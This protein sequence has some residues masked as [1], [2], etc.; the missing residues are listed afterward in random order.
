MVSLD[1]SSP[2]DFGSRAVGVLFVSTDDSVPASGQMLPPLT[3]TAYATDL[4]T[5]LADRLPKPTQFDVTT[6]AARLTQADGLGI[7]DG[8]DAALS[9]LSAVHEM[10]PADPH[11]AFQDFAHQFVQRRLSRSNVARRSEARWL[12]EH[13]NEVLL[14]MMQNVLYA[15]G[16]W[17]ESRTLEQWRDLVSEDAARQVE[18]EWTRLVL[19]Q[20]S[21]SRSAEQLER[22]LAATPSGAYRIVQALEAAG[23]LRGGSVLGLEPR[24]LRCWLRQAAETAVFDAGALAW[25][26]LL[27]QESTGRL[28]RE[29]LT[30]TL[31]N[32][33]RRLFTLLL[34]SPPDERS[35]EW[36]L[37][38]ESV[39]E[40]AGDAILTG[41][42]LDDL[43]LMELWE[44]QGSLVL[45]LD[46]YATPRTGC[47][48]ADQ[49]RYGAWLLRTWA[50]AEQLGTVAALP[51][52]CPWPSPDELPTSALDAVDAYLRSEASK[53]VSN[54]PSRYA[55]AGYSLVQR[56]F[57]GQRPLPAH[58]LFA[59]VRLID[60]PS[61]GNA[62][63]LSALPH[64][65]SLLKALVRTGFPDLAEAIW[66]SWA[67]GGYDAGAHVLA[68]SAPDA[69]VVWPHL[70]GPILS[71]MLRLAHEY[72]RCLPFPHLSMDA[73]RVLV[74]TEDALDDD[75]LTYL[76]FALLAGTVE[77]LSRRRDTER[78]Q[79]LWSRF[80]EPV[81]E[82][83]R[84]LVETEQWRL[85]APLLSAAP[86]E[87]AP[88]ALPALAE[89]L[90]RSGLADPM[91]LL[92]RGWLQWLSSFE[93][94]SRVQAYQ[95]LSEIEALL[96][97][98]RATSTYEPPSSGPK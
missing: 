63:P 84:A 4:C 86:A 24:W 37:T 27:L 12:R 59:F 93:H 9:L 26:R 20:D 33:P 83:L 40:L 32:D 56:L 79:V 57:S 5:W 47:S 29:R 16:P 18:T 41:T 88:R 28:M 22:A 94:P 39:F 89:R 38:V 78:L 2:V 44:L 62:L 17:D 87:L 68:P 60:S 42:Q 74:L 69:G 53:T 46:D 55:V 71:S 36:A 65:L 72:T 98:V 67:D 43:L 77:T 96:S 85:V 54:D 13:A 95:L 30:A 3:P 81:Y 6:A 48:P 14:A 75:A 1:G 49:T 50:V 7:I 11:G 97:H 92:A 82:V 58:P 8:L 19:L 10:G 70:P 91:T 76:P 51:L 80:L 45:T 66:Q 21:K 61:F 52:L 73:Y 35:I 31:N 34:Q 25:G 23:I 64:A 15:A 90:S